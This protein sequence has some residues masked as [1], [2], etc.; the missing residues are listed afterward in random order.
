MKTLKYFVVIPTW[1][2]VNK[3]RKI[4][5]EWCCF[6]HPNKDKGLDVVREQ[7]KIKRQIEKLQ[8]IGI[9]VCLKV[10]PSLRQIK[11]S[12]EAGADAVSF[13]SHKTTELR[14]AKSFA[15]KLGLDVHP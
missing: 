11:A 7:N 3:A 10:R 5:P 8:F 13:C 9:E 12:Y 2:R 15:K 14:K 1:P 4:R 6:V